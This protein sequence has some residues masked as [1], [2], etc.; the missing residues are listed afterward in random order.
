MSKDEWK[1]GL[2]AFVAALV[3]FLLFFAVVSV[4]KAQVEAVSESPVDVKPVDKQAEVERAVENWKLMEN[5][6]VDAQQA[7]DDAL[8]IAKEQTGWWESFAQFIGISPVPEESALV[9]QQALFEE[10]KSLADETYN[11]EK[12]ELVNVMKQNGTMSHIYTKREVCG[13]DANL[14]TDAYCEYNV[15]E[16]VPAYVLDYQLVVTPSTIY[17]PS[18]S[19]MCWQDDVMIECE[20]PYRCDMQ[21]GLEVGCEARILYNGVGSEW[22]DAVPLVPVLLT[23]EDVL[24]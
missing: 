24:Q 1:T 14:S 5:A 15:E 18:S 4:A 22:G 2:Y 7:Y 16:F 12:N 20:N 8:V 23:S 17:S 10:R 21:E 9:A 19:E 6:S 13:W 3:V 11:V